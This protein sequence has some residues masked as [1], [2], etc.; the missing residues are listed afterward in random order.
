MT[1]TCF[2]GC[3]PAMRQSVY[4]FARASGRAACAH[5]SS[6]Y[7]TPLGP[8][9]EAFVIDW[10]ACAISIGVTSVH[11]QVVLGG[12]SLGW[13]AETLIGFLGKMRAWRRSSF[14]PGFSAREPSSHWSAGKTLLIQPLQ[15]LAMCH[16]SAALS[17]LLSKLSAQVCFAFFIVWRSSWNAWRHVSPDGA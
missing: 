14:S 7:P 11:F 10:R 6:L 13:S 4:I 16:I 1:I 15:T 3:I 5:L 17:I 8:G 2:H 12:G 9:A